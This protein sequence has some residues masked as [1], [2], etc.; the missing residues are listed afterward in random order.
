M[1]EPRAKEWLPAYFRSR[2]VDTLPS[3]EIYAAGAAAG[4]SQ[5]ALT[6]AWKRLRE[7]GYASTQHMGSGR[8]RRAQW[9]YDPSPRRYPR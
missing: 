5:H 8:D 9:T 4:I 1:N 7:L 3:R 6:V 2:G